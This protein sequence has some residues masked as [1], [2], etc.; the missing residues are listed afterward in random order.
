MNQR[1]GVLML[2]VTAIVWGSGFVIT[3]IGLQYLNAYQLMAGRFLVA[4]IILIII[5]GYKF[6]NINKRLVIK[7]TILGA[8]L[9][10]GFVLQ[11][12]GLE[13]T[14]PSKN[15][16]LTAVN[17]LVVPLI[18][19]AVYKRKIDRFEI[20]GALT[21]LIGI[22]LLSLQGSLSMNVGDVLTLLCA[23]A[24][25]FD[26]FYTNKFVKNEDAILLTVIQFIAAAI[27]SVIFVLVRGDIP[28]TAIESEGLYSILYLAIISTIIA[29]L[30][31]N[32]AFKYTTA[33]QGAIILSM[34]SLFGMIFSV[35]FLHEILTGRMI[36]GATL[37]FL[38]IIFSEVKPTFSKKRKLQLHNKEPKV[39]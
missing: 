3:D 15:A 11:T 23:V 39:E 28:T 32:I 9:Y 38:A 35:I 24:F 26:I 4:A 36:I 5:F 19:F 27:I 34:E 1:I 14:T 17:V 31:Q 8:I 22:A 20:I 29:Y 30:L 33:T 6:K 10:T 37:I 12:V 25:A 21:A 2:M 18:A 13:Y 16:F 7:G